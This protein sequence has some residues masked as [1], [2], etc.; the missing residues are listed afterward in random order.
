MTTGA[1]QILTVVADQFLCS[2]MHR[3]VDG[4]TP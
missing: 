3:M 1:G 4:A 2:G